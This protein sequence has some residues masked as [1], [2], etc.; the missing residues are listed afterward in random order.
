M[1]DI[2]KEQPKTFTSFSRNAADESDVD[3]A[4]TDSEGVSLFTG[5]R[6]Y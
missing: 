2:N 1:I 5:I 6:V 4:T 3:D